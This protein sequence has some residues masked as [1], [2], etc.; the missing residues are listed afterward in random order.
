MLLLFNDSYLLVYQFSHSGYKWHFNCDN[1]VEGQEWKYEEKRPTIGVNTVP[2]RMTPAAID[3]LQ[4]AA[5][6]FLVNLFNDAVHVQTT[7]TKDATLMTKHI[8]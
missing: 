3:A 8:R 6:S 4:V 1:F 2:V 7:A 5:E